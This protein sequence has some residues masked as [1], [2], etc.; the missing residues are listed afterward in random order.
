MRL[1]VAALL[2]L[3]TM[4]GAA[5]AQLPERQIKGT[6]IVSQHDPAVSITLPASARYA[7]S[8]RFLLTD[9]KI[10]PFDDCELHVFVETDGHDLRRLYWV[11][12][13]AYLA[14]HPN[15]H[16][17]YDSPRHAR[18]GGLDFYVDTWVSPANERSDRGSD[19]D[20]LN[21]LL[22]K[23][24]ITHGDLASIRLVH[25]TDA[26]KR[27]ELMVIYS[28]DLA[29]TGFTAAQLQPGGSAHDKWPSIERALIDRA[30]H[31]VRVAPASMN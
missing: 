9:P 17:T 6:T 23:R 18:I 30:T 1:V 7:G 5:A 10:G 15:M 16:H 13:E 26:T 4:A 20:H 22:T 28:E 21:T 29:T 14:S 8:D 11:Q 27:K 31:A 12:F 25:L 24:G 3:A 19:T 2:A